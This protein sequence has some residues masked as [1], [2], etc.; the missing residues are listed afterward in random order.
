LAQPIRMVD[1]K[2]DL[3]NETSELLL[4]WLGM[5]W[6]LIKLSPNCVNV[7]II[8]LVDGTYHYKSHRKVDRIRK[9]T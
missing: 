7:E 4:S 5:E 6:T 2:I 3:S 8:M 9:P 1:F